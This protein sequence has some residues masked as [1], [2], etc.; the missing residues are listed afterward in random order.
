[1]KAR[2]SLGP[3]CGWQHISALRSADGGPASRWDVH[4]SCG[5][6]PRQDTGL[7]KD[8]AIGGWPSNALRGGQRFGAAHR[9]H[10]VARR[11]SPR[12]A[13]VSC[14]TLATCKDGLRIA[15]CGLRACRVERER[16]GAGWKLGFGVRSSAFR[17]WGQ[18]FGWIGDRGASN[19]KRA[20]AL[21]TAYG[22]ARGA[23]L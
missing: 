2:S 17:R 19:D 12:G 5:A 3:I 14:S 11:S 20:T 4:C 21:G 23:K 16:F 8:R 6:Q 10:T 15:L 9:W 7:A 18:R 1:L 22:C 13:S